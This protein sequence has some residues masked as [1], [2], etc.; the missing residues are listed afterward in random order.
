MRR[1][2]LV[3]FRRRWPALARGR[4]GPA[5]MTS[6]P[7]L[8]PSASMV[9]KVARARATAALR[10]LATVSAKRLGPRASVWP[11]LLAGLP[12]L[13]RA[14]SGRL[15]DAVGR[16]DVLSVLLELAGGSVDAARLERALVTLWLGLAGHPGL[17]SPLVLPGPFRER[18]VDP[19]A[20][21][22]LSLEEVRGL[23]ATAQ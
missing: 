19:G 8:S 22:L 7:W 23:V 4:A 13:L 9:A 6:H 14:D 2:E 12:A 18:V 11:P 5:Q 1:A 20:P 17:V 10:D 21:R 16:V 15:L 3:C